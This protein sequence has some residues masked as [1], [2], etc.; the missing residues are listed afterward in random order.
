MSRLL[1]TT[2]VSIGGI[3]RTLEI[4]ENKRARRII[5]RVDPKTSYVK[6]TVPLE[7]YV[8]D[9]RALVSREEAWLASQ[10]ESLPSKIEFRPGITFPYRGQRCEIVHR[11]ESRRGAWLEWREVASLCR[12]G[13]EVP[14]LHVSGNSE[15]VP[16]RVQDWLKRKAKQELTDLCSIYGR[17]LGVTPSKIAVRDTYSRW[18]SCSSHGTL[19]FSWR[20]IM[21]PD[22]VLEYVA[23]HESAHRI[24]MDHSPAFWRVVDGLVSCRSDAQVWL[25]THGADLFRYG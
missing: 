2:T 22:A 23:A 25:R 10:F 17:M 3:D 13:D 7:D 15:H 16:R 20:L 18:G 9:A 14:V 21:A 5:V 1:N 24:H 6:A 4:S 11:P 12:E 19:S 8:D